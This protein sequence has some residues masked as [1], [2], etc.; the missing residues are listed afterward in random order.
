MPRD[1]NSCNQLILLL[2]FI[3]KINCL[4]FVVSCIVSMKQT[5]DSLRYL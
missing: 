5:D 3:I 4:D 1:I 2:V